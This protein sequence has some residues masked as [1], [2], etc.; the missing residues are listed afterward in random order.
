[1]KRELLTAIVVAALSFSAGAQSESQSGVAG[2]TNHAVRGT[3]GQPTLA[4]MARLEEKLRL[5]SRII[6]GMES[7]GTGRGS[8]SNWRLST[9]SELYQLSNEELASMQGVHSLNDL[10]E[11]IA[12]AKRVAP[13]ALGSGTDD[14]TYTP[15]TPCRYID[16]RDVG[17]KI[18]G[19][20][21]FDLDTNAYTTA[22]GKCVS[23]PLTTFGSTLFALAVNMAI[24]DTSVAPGVATI[25]PTGAPTN[26]ALVN[27]YQAG[28]SVQASNA[29]IVTID[30]GLAAN[31]IDVVTS[32]SVH[33]IVDV[34]GGFRANEATA[35]DCVS[36]FSEETGIANNAAFNFNIAVC[37]AGY[38]MTGAG[39]RTPGLTDAIR[40][41]ING[42]F[43]T[44]AGGAIGA[45]C[46]G[47][48]V[49]GGPVS[50]QG[51][52]QCCRVP[53]R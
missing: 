29:A 3:S 30:Q 10:P 51:T 15:I 38:A 18:N 7:R 26:T 49:S 1:M 39:C 22:A 2:A 9:M 34:F 11:A 32:S 16:T 35:L 27:W 24:F 21:G 47:Q 23:A 25:V 46:A 45:F 43:Q 33:V 44:V 42:L 13:K 50:I 52:R 6:A 19:T 48:N 36:T 5:V 17:G 14:L 12:K 8:S 41:S 20:R 37:P 53:G 4:Q 40:W 28:P 31:E